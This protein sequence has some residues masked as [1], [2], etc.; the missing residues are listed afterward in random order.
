MREAKP[1]KDS[2]KWL[3]ATLA[4]CL[5][6]DIFAAHVLYQH[7]GYLH[8]AVGLLV[9][10]QYGGYGA[11]YGYA[12]AVEGVHKLR[13][14]ALFPA[15]AYLGAARLEVLKVGA[16]AYLHI[17]AV[18]GHPY[19]YVVGL[20]A[21][22]AQIACGEHYYMIGQAEALQHLLGVP[23]QGFQLVI[24]VLGLCELNKLHLVELMLADKPAGI[25]ACGAGL[26]AEAARTQDRSR[27][28]RSRK[29]VSSQLRQ[30]P[31]MS[32]L[33]TWTAIRS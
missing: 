2:L 3:K 17:P 8:G 20:G 14:G 28:I 24:A 12:G 30:K 25:A 11:A 1:E 18:A 4:K 7:I 16:G 32:L 13:L 27:W 19:L 5:L 6:S 15:E 21:G 10:L 29:T 23:G 31:L 26:A 9:I 22:E 33:N